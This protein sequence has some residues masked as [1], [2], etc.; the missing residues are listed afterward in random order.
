MNK[1]TSLLML[2]MLPCWMAFGA[3]TKVTAL[4]ANTDPQSTDILY[5]VDDPGGTPL[6]QKITLANLAANMPDVIV[7]GSDIS[8]GAAGVKLTGDGDGSITFLGL[9]N[10]TDEDL[11]LNLDDTA[12]TGVISSSTALDK[13]TLTDIALSTSLATD[14]SSL[15][16]G[17]IIAAGGLA[18]AKQI[19]VGD[20]I[21]MS[22]SGTGVYDITLKDNVADALSI[23]RGT[24]DVM[25]FDTETASPAITITPATTITGDLTETGAIIANGAV[26][27]GNA[28]TDITTLTGKIAG[29]SPISFD[30]NTADTVYTIFAMDDP[31]SSSKTITF[32]AVTGQVMLGSAATVITAGATPTLTVGDGN[33]TFTDTITTDNQDQTITFS[34]AGTVGD[35]I[36]IIFT[37]DTGGSGDE[38]ITFETTLTQSE[39]TLT[40]ANLTAGQYVVSFI[41]NGSVWIE[42]SRTAAL[43]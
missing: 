36:T 20:D 23:V 10:G 32:P 4:T 33:Q 38:V 31:T 35:R 19:Y 8:V 43:S 1:L 13:L 16:T 22:V 39:G 30:G 41:S 27:L 28:V 21:D 40:L 17:S 34:G 7:L 29:A 11:T 2:L 5:M 24:T 3:D 26:T 42:T 6:S 18:V 14:A 37:T 25:V 15:T 9:G 12:N